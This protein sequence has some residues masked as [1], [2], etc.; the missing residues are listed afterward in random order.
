MSILWEMTFLFSHFVRG[1][2]WFFDQINITYT[3]SLEVS[4]KKKNLGT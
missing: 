2:T 1:I 4:G 3:K